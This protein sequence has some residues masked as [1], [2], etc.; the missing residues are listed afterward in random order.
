MTLYDPDDP[1]KIHNLDLKPANLKTM[2]FPTTPMSFLFFR[3]KKPTKRTIEDSFFF[4]F[5]FYFF[6]RFGKLSKLSKLPSQ[7]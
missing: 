6:L 1:V 2:F 3:A 5:F 7:M 4:Y